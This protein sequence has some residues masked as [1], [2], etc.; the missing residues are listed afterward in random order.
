MR[1]I[2]F[3]I[4]AIFLAI[5][6][7]T[8]PVKQNDARVIAFNYFIHFSGKI[9]P[10]L[11]NSFSVEYDGS[12]VYHAFNFKDGGFVIVSADDAVIPILAESADGSVEP[13]MANS[14]VKYW[15]ECYSKE[16]LA[17]I[18]AKAD[19]MQTLPQWNRIRNNEFDR[20]TADVGPLVTTTWDQ[21]EWYNYYCPTDPGGFGGHALVG[22]VAT[23]VGQIMKYHSF[24]SHGFLSHSY[25]H[26]V[27]GTLSA[28]FGETTYNWEAMG[29]S[30]NSSGYEDIARL[31]F[32]VGVA[33]EMNYG[34]DAS[35]AK[36][37]GLPWA[38][39]TYF[40][41][42]PNF[43]GLAYKSDYSDP[44]W[45]ELLKADL[46][47]F[48]P[49]YYAGDDGTNGHAWVCD[50][51]RSSDDLFHMNWGWSGLANGWYAMGALNPDFHQL[52]NNNMVVKGIK[53]GKTDLIVRITNLLP[54][55]IIGYGPTIGI[56][57]EVI[58]GTSNTVN[59]YFD[60]DVIYTTSQQ[61]FVYDLVTT[62]Y[63]MGTHLIRVEALNSTDTA[64]HEVTVGNCGWKRQASAFSTVGRGI[65]HLDVVDSLVVWATAYDGNDL[66][67]YIQEFT[68][69][70][71]GGLTW[72]PGIIPNCAGLVPSMI[73]AMNADTAYCPM[74]RQTG[75]NPPGIYVTRNGGTDWIQQTSASFSNSASFPNVVHFF[76][77]NEGFCMGDPV[78]NEFEIY[79][80]TDGGTTWTQVPGGNIADPLSE[81][82]GVVGYYSV[83]G[84][85]AW[86]GTSRGRVYRSSD[87][88]LHWDVSSTTLTEK[89]VDV[90]FNNGLHGLA[91]D[92][93]LG[94]T[95]SLSET[96]D[97]GITW[98]PVTIAGHV[99]TYDF[100]YVPGTDNTWIS[101]EAGTSL[102]AYYSYDGGHSWALFAGTNT[103]QF[104]AV[105]FISNSIGWAGGFNLGMTDGGMFRFL[106]TLPAGT[107]L[108]P[109][110]SLFAV[111]TGQYVH[112][113]WASP[114]FG[115]V[116]GYNVYRN[117]TLLTASPVSSLVYDDSPVPNGSQTYCV[118][119]VHQTGESE[120][121]CTDALVTFGIPEYEADIMI[122]PNPAN[123]IINI[124][125]PATFS[126]VSLFNLLGHK[127]YDYAATGKDLTILTQGIKPGVY[128]LLITLEGRTVKR[129]ISIP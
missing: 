2:T 66:T 30:A 102:G 44:Q 34:P 80:T 64:Y 3:L 121:V 49:L 16:I 75:Y 73:F 105:K 14:S 101:T 67:N 108:G 48:L 20:S 77:K 71:D 11:D 63:S 107:V 52:N 83:V 84:N 53:P 36:S 41:Y 125:S 39:I 19:N 46:N 51:W 22:C 58:T 23:A 123:E 27:Y 74:Y 21:A 12:I 24:P 127:V 17:I 18:E 93:N 79:T 31:L 92:K 126:Q 13:D 6:G 70:L 33:V 82:Y 35:G 128:F 124:K 117:N 81:E 1:K 103:D 69:T 47:A 5:S 60:N 62:D 97:G 85:K 99:G 87:K 26:P 111:V 43:I 96:F 32:H 7:F 50:G 9:N 37:E 65:S 90:E 40:N 45:K 68:R 72:T 86:F 114:A 55:Q 109:V 38:L 4:A 91:Q 56:D 129:K 116:L 98:L 59:L 94:S 112:L 110:S 29:N 78:N 95:G 25:Q 120:A 113:E 88:G 76:N 10:V 61:S 28:N 104:L 118:T 15:F 100:C 119:A 42:N 8:N 89:Y 122:Y 54:D 106:G 115:N 57:C